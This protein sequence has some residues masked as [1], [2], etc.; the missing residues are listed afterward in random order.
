MVE[1]CWFKLLDSCDVQLTENGFKE[2]E[3][4]Y[5]AVISHLD[6]LIQPSYTLC[7]QFKPLAL[8][9]GLL[10]RLSTSFTLLLTMAIS[11]LAKLMCKLF[12]RAMS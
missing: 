9:H 7:T 10:A 3:I 8:P 12:S 1:S 5:L 11:A 4:A 6:K 2:V